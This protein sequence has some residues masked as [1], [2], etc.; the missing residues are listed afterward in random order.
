M[1]PEHIA[2]GGHIVHAVVELVGR[3]LELGVELVDL[4]GQELRV[5][6]VP[7]GHHG[8]ADDSQDEGVHRGLLRCVGG[9]MQ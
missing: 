8:D 1:A 2:V 6:E 4:L 3:G 5:Q 9:Q 7:G